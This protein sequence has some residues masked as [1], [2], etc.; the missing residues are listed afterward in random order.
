MG[1]KNM[2]SITTIM[3]V[4]PNIKKRKRKRREK[5]RPFSTILR[6]PKA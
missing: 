6:P 5:E 1:K 2:Q 4:P 3:S